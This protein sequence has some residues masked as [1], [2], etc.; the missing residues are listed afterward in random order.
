MISCSLSHPHKARIGRVDWRFT[1]LLLPPPK[2]KVQKKIHNGNVNRGIIF[3]L[4][5]FL[6]SPQR[7]S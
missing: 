1:L 7:A 3:N 6:L 2:T 5:F 4:R